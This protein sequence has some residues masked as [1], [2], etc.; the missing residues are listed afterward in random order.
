MYRKA[1]RDVVLCDGTRI[2]E[3]TLLAVDSLN[4]HH[5]CAVYSGAGAFDP[6]R[7]ARMREAGADEGV[8]HQLVNTSLG[9]L[10]FGHGKHAWYAC[11]FLIL[12]QAVV[13]TK[14][15]CGT[16]PDGSSRQAS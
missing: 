7:F 13:L 10:T 14:C 11:R 12:V 8:R 15:A 5:D 9:F 3:G 16:V 4:A 2:P 6:F 1:M